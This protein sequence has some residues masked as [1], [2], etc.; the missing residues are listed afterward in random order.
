MP[1]ISEL[2]GNPLC[3]IEERI[4]SRITRNRVDSSLRRTFSCE[5]ASDSGIA[6]DSEALLAPLSKVWIA[7]CFCFFSLNDDIEEDNIFKDYP[8]IHLN[9]I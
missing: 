2:A 1:Q 8:I 3:W 6:K 5:D 9:K 4:S 7:I